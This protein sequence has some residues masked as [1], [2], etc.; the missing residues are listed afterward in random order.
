MKKFLF[1]IFAL[2]MLSARLPAQNRVTA[3]LSAAAANCLTTNV[4]Q[5]LA[6]PNMGSVTFTVSANAS[7]NTIQFEA[8]ANFGPGVTTPT[9]VALNATP[10]N[11]TTAATSTTST[12]TWQANIG[13]YTA[14]RLRMSTLAGGTTT[15]TISTS[16]VSARSGGGGGGAG[17]V[18]S[19]ATTS[20][21]TGGTI[22]TTGTIA[23]A[24]CVTSAASLT[25]NAVVIGGGSQ[26]SSTISADTT[27]THALF[28]TAGAPAFRALA[29]GDLP[30]IAIPAVVSSATSGGFPCFD[31]ATDMN[32][33]AAI[34]AGVL[35]KGG[36]AGACGAASSV[37]DNGTTVAT[38]EP[39]NTTNTANSY[40]VNGT[41]IIKFPNGDLSST[42]VGDGVLNA[43]TTAN[44][45]QSTCVGRSSCASET[46]TIG[47]AITALGYLALNAATGTNDV[48]IGASTANA[49]AADNNEIELGNSVTGA[50]SNT[51]T[52]GNVS[53]TDAYFG[54]STAAAIAHASAV[55]LGG[56]NAFGSFVNYATAACETTFAATTVSGGATT[57]TGLNCLPA[58]S[59]I[60][61]VVYRI[62]TTI[63]TAV[64]FTIG[65]AGSATRYC[66]T[67]ST[68]TSGTTGTCTAQ[69]YYLNTSAAGVVFTPN[70]TPGA[71]AIR[72]IVYYH[73]W[74]APTS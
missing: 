6:T 72:L 24:T 16:P 64:S 34:G 21:I 48:G 60:D 44:N 11:S 1:L 3:T 50:G 23:C 32:T 51:A 52:I 46:S 41:G 31:S 53:V 29:S 56:G 62:T 37:T 12:G 61:A 5:A 68:L 19:V 54:S 57:T 10:S 67:Q 38:T 74:T 9:W 8:S 70:T 43:L 27:T 2:L 13:A 36:G 69:G 71:G 58:N 25:S 28:A 26:A 39:F 47:N 15:V 30:A 42:A 65:D 7:G 45:G 40:E 22:T 55:K 33:T 20:P 4:C 73:T 35:L 14:V 49:S 17:T 66:G 59:I 18:T 63:T